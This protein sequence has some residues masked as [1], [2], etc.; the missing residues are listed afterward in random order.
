MDREFDAAIEAGR[1]AIAIRPGCA[2]ANGFF[3]N[4]LHYCGQQ[5]EAIAHI[6]RSIRLQPVYP[7]FLASMLATAYLAAGQ[8]ES[9]LA[10]AKEALRLNPRD[11]QAR[12]VLL[13]ANQL[14]GNQQLARTFGREIVRLEPAFSV[15]MYSRDQPYRDRETIDPMVNA[16]LAAGLPP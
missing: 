6:K 8:V 10:V 14:L 15:D 7:P 2:N 9:A 5:A 12:L 4:V 11:L 1:Q 13:A 3:G 16:W